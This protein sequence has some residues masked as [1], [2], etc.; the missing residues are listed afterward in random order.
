MARFSP[1]RR[2]YAEAKGEGQGAHMV[3]NLAG[4]GQM[5]VTTFLLLLGRPAS[6]KEMPD[7][8]NHFLQS[9]RSLQL[10]DV[11]A[12]VLASYRETS[13]AMKKAQSPH[14]TLVPP[15]FHSGPLTATWQL[16]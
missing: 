13:E 9:M 1:Q 6:P 10:L 12:T 16:R 8:I 2:S 15:A 14:S 3:K 11:D 4:E 5:D 7:L